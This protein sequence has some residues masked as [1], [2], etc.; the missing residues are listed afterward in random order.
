MGLLGPATMPLLYVY[1][2]YFQSTPASLSSRLWMGYRCRKR[3]H[4]SAHAH[5]TGMSTS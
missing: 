3:M 1:V 2:V 4:A 5:L